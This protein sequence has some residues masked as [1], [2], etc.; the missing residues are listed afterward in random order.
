VSITNCINAQDCPDAK[1]VSAFL[2]QGTV[3]EY[4]KE[5]PISIPV[6]SKVRFVQSWCAIDRAT[7]DSNM[8]YYEFIFVIDQ[9][10]YAS[11]I[12][13][14]YT[15]T[16]DE[17]DPTKTYPCMTAAVVL[18]GW[19]I[20]E[21]HQV[22]TGGKVLDYINDGWDDYKPGADMISYVISPVAFTATPTRTRTLTKAPT[23][24]YVPWTPTVACTDKG[25]IKINNRTSGTVTLYLK[26]PASYTFYLAVG[27]T[28]ISVCRG[29]YSY[30][31]YG[32]G[33]ASKTGSMTTGESHEFFCR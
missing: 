3:V 28:N 7:L 31:A 22:I 1:N 14:D 29:S 8:K 26:G 10:S 17:K 23:W 13:K 12:K 4:N 18:S 9:V 20:G 25:E 21:K 32:C 6:G 5:Y 24:T 30:T 11:S 33:G 16:K 19:K 15:T 27:N 2:P